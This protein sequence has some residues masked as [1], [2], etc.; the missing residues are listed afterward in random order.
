VDDS[1]HLAAHLC[2]D[3]HDEFGLSDRQK[4]DLMGHA[5]ISMMKDAYV[6]RGELHAD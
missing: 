4:A 2:H 3:L 5:K 1:A 6:H